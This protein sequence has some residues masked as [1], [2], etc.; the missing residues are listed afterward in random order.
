MVYLQASVSVCVHVSSGME[1][2]Y[3]CE[4]ETAGGKART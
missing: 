1:A 2:N 4:S 3:K